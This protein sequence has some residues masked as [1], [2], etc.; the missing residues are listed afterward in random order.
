MTPSQKRYF[1]FSLA[2]ILLMAMASIANA[3][4]QHL[5]M[6]NHVDA[7]QVA[8]Q[9]IPDK[10]DTTEYWLENGNARVNMG[11]SASFIYHSETK[12]MYGLNHVD[13]SYFEFSVGD[14]ESLLEREMG[15]DAGPMM[16]QM[17][18]MFQVK[19]TVTPTEET[20][21]IDDWN[22]TK[23]L[24]KVELMGT[25]VP[26]EIWTTTDINMDANIYSIASNAMKAILP[27]FDGMMAE[28][29]KIKG[30]TVESSSET[31]FNGIVMKTHSK[32]IKYEEAS[33]PTGAYTVPEGY[34][35]TD[36]QMPGGGK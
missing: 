3:A 28:L 30:V 14:F 12:T 34:K 21:K 17:K 11:D 2:L 6:E 22:C 26:T 20:K 4:A 9:T 5:L 18:A 32:L 19:A 24:S 29:E 13:K 15:A 35:K 8:G 27:G 23:Y 33:A 36:M 31:N 7:Y 25:V 10:T 1:T 16:E